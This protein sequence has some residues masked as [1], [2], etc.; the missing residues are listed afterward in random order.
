MAR[1]AA[2]VSGAGADVGASAWWGERPGD[3]ALVAAAGARAGGGSSRSAAESAA[4]GGGAIDG[5]GDGAVSCMAVAGALGIDEA[6]LLALVIVLATVV[7][8]AADAASRALT[9]R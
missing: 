3:R 5:A 8:L 2:E 4:S 1:F 9:P 6:P 7:A